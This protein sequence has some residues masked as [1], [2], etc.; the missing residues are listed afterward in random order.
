M[1]VYTGWV[2]VD[3]A[4]GG[5]SVHREEFV[6]FLCVSKN[7]VQ[8]Y[9]KNDLLDF[10]VTVAP[11]SV[12]DDDDEANVAAVDDARVTLEP[13]SFSGVAGSP[14]CLV[15]RA[16]VAALNATVHRITYQVTVLTR[17]TEALDTIKIRSASTPK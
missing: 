16:D 3:F 13:Q 5:G 12:A 11:A 4:G 15:L 1:E 2:G 14:L 6:S 17:G 8:Q 7:T 10:T 9:L